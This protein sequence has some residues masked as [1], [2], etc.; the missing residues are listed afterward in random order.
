MLREG[1][2]IPPTAP[3]WKKNRGLEAESWELLYVERM[4]LYQKELEDQ[5][6]HEEK[7]FVDLS[8]DE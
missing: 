4:N 6:K 1:H 2:P 3:Q 8:I 5:H 7:I